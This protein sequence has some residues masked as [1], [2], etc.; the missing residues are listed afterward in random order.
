MKV[1]TTL[2]IVA[3]ALFATAGSQVHFAGDAEARSYKKSFSKNYGYKNRWRN[4]RIRRGVAIGVGTAVG[5][6][7]AYNYSCSNLAYRC[8]HGEYWAC[9]RF[10]DRC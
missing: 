5:V 9:S 8:R 3:I 10:D 1:M 6:G 4:R 2:A 7:L